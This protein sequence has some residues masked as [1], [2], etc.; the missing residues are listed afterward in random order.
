MSEDEIINILVKLLST[1]VPGYLSYYVLY[2][3]DIINVQKS[4]DTEN[5]I[6]LYL[7]SG[8]SCI[9]SLAVLQQHNANTI[10]SI[11]GY[12]IATSVILSFIC[13]PIVAP[14]IAK[15]VNFYINQFRLKNQKGYTDPISI[16]KD[17][18]DK[19]IAPRVTIFD[20]SGNLII[21]G[22]PDRIPSDN[23]FEPL[24][25][26]FT[27]RIP[28]NT[29]QCTETEIIEAYRDF[30][31]KGDGIYKIYIDFERKLKFHIFYES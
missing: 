16:Y 7:L 8:I 22:L 21:S 1:S 29:L 26:V 6:I 17:V 20:F 18:L 5:K 19:K 12:T 27:S 31:A 4:R 28:V 24:E 9:I 11:I 25:F 2:R 14:Y 15:G 3:L 10:W 13:I 30:E 23:Q